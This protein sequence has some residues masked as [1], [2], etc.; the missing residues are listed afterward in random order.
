MSQD[1]DLLPPTIT[2]GNVAGVNTDNW[3]TTAALSQTS[4]DAE[5]DSLSGSIELRLNP[6]PKLTTGLSL[7]Y[8]EEEND[9][10][11][12]A[13][14]PQTDQFGYIAQDS[15][16]IKR[17]HKASKKSGDND[18]HY[19][20]IPF[21]KSRRAWKLDATYRLMRKT[22]LGMEWR[23]TTYKYDEREV[24]ESDETRIK[25]FLSTRALDWATIRVSYLSEDRDADNYEPNP[26]SEYYTRSLPDFILSARPFT[27]DE[28]RKFDVGDVDREKFEG[29]MNVLIRD[30]M[31]LML[32]AQYENKD[33]G[34]SLKSGNCGYTTATKAASCVTGPTTDSA[35][36]KVTTCLFRQ[37]PTT[38]TASIQSVCLRPIAIDVDQFIEAHSRLSRHLC[39]LQ[40]GDPSYIASYDFDSF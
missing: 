19:R 10:S 17:I 40:L 30:D 2:S 31:D 15:P 7:D 22:T 3:N 27:L 23:E 4:A 8:Y 21:D 24:E 25:V 38:I 1:E 39:L 34:T 29:R 35:L 9:T 18:I 16:R 20:S 11:Y 13:Y 14:N 6:L 12:T 32:S 26:Y 33:Y 28:M 36:W 37:F 5:I